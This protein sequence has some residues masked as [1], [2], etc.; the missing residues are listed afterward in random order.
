MIKALQTG[1]EV[2]S[3][4]L[5]RL[6]SVVLPTKWKRRDLALLL[7][8]DYREADKLLR[9]WKKEGLVRKS[10]REPSS[11]TFTIDAGAGV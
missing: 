10:T 9:I 4:E 8:L 2:D 1:Q 11:W 7:Q 6:T 5:A 3:E